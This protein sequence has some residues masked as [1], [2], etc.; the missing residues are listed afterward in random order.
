[1]KFFA[2]CISIAAVALAAGC[3]KDR[4][5][6]A[7]VMRRSE[8]PTFLSAELAALFGQRNFSARA[9]V[10][11]HG[12]TSIGDFSARNGSLAFKAGDMSALWD[13]LTQKAYL[14]SEPLQ[15]YAPMRA[16]TNEIEVLAKEDGLPTRFEIA[17]SGRVVILNLSKI[18]PLAAGT[19]EFSIPSGFKAYETSESMLSELDL[20]RRDLIRA[21]DQ[22]RA[23]KYGTSRAAEDP[24]KLQPPPRY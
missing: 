17:G 8:P 9:E 14:F 19:D 22:A 16:I 5:D 7:L 12:S 2:V 21:R 4:E 10:T 6:Q 24:A 18:R 15:A 11:S 20:R 23:E 1:M 13:A 3:A